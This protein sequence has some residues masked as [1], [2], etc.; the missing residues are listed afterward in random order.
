M[1][2]EVEKGLCKGPV[3]DHLP[4]FGKGAGANA[5]NENLY[6]RLI[7]TIVPPIVSR[8]SHSMYE[9]RLLKGSNDC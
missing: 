5:T 1:S 3:A 6:P 4:S 2:A 9:A 7:F 8:S